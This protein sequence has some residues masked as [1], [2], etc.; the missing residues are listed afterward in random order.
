MEEKKLLIVGGTSSIYIVKKDNTQY[1]TKEYKAENLDSL[2]KEIKVY[3]NIKSI[4]QKYFL[5]LLGNGKNYINLEFL[6]NTIDLFSYLDA[7]DDRKLSEKDAKFIFKQIVEAVIELLKKR[8]IHG[9]LKDENVLINKE[10]KEIKLIDFGCSLYLP[11]TD[12]KIKEITNTFVFCPP[13]FH[14]TGVM[15]PMEMT[16]WSLGTILYIMLNGTEPFEETEEGFIKRYHI[17]NNINL[18][19]DCNNIINSLL[20]IDPKKRLSVC[21]ILSHKWFNE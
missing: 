12:F 6:D 11:K 18:T 10:T 14:K 3:K 4:N 19:S 5:K 21:D 2:E 20:S 9:D 15:K 1:I 7:L 8:I 13:E 17:N 16:S